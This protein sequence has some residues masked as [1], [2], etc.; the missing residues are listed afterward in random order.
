MEGS[1]PTRFPHVEKWLK[2]IYSNGMKVL[3]A[4]C[5]GGPYRSL[6]ARE[7]YV[8]FDLPSSWYESLHPPSL[9]ASADALPFQTNTFDL[10]FSVS[11]FDYFP[12]PL[13]ALEEMRRCSR[14]S[15]QV[16]IFTYDESTLRGIHARAADLPESPSIANHHVFTKNDLRKYA[17]AA[18]LQIDQMPETPYRSGIQ[19]L[20][21]V[22][23][24]STARVFRLTPE[25]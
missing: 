9:F 22:V 21:R 24:P 6:F 25:L 14:P 4:G 17:E 2:K 16:W 3:E 5:G 19:R 10:I 11:A 7:G 13:V 23:R 12:Q 15:G 8:G 1:A 18:R 20:K